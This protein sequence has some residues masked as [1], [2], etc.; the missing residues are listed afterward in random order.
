MRI[1]IALVTACLTFRANTV[2]IEAS[3]YP[4]L[5]KNQEEVTITK[6]GYWVD[7]EEGRAEVELSFDGIDKIK[8]ATAPL[9]VIFVVD[10]ST[11]MSADCNN[12]NHVSFPSYRLDDSAHRWTREVFLNEVVPLLQAEYSKENGMIRRL[13]NG[14]WEID[15]EYTVAL[16]QAGWIAYPNIIAATSASGFDPFGTHLDITWYIA[17]T[18]VT[19]LEWENY[20]LH[21]RYSDKENKILGSRIYATT[22]T[23]GRTTVAMLRYPNSLYASGDCI[24]NLQA[25]YAAINTLVENIFSSTPESHIAITVFNGAVGRNSTNPYTGFMRDYEK[26]TMMDIYW[27]AA[28]QHLTANLGAYTNY[29]AAFRSVLKTLD[30]GSFHNGDDHSNC[31]NKQIV[32]F[33]TD[34]MPTAHCNNG[35]MTTEV[36]ATF[37]VPYNY[38]KP[39]V[40][41]IHK[42]D[43]EIYVATAGIN[44]SD[45]SLNEV[46]AMLQEIATSPKHRYHEKDYEG[47]VFDL[48]Y[49]DIFDSIVKSKELALVDYIDNRYFVVD[50]AA[51][52]GNKNFQ[53]FP[54]Y[55]TVKVEKV[56]IDGIAVQKVSFLYAF[57]DKRNSIHSVKIPLILAEGVQ[58]DSEAGFIPSNYD[59]VAS[60]GGAYASYINLEAEETTIAT[61]RVWLKINNAENPDDNDHHNLIPHP[62]LNEN[63][64]QTGDYF[65]V[66]LFL[67]IIGMASSSLVLALFIKKRETN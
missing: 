47:S 57:S 15:P 26:A 24:S 33:F 31:E 64:P 3:N 60:E 30:D 58:A 11:S 53:Y 41:E 49:E 37:P 13:P 61:S 19:Q 21:Y 44:T 6:K 35:D 39:I 32:I 5:T 20:T 54:E 38:A 40:Q 45:G 62:P 27:N 10:N 14:N 34:G 25:N 2:I 17:N 66:P 65:N 67:S 22:V 18:N 43:I 12:T 28:R 29:E 7:Q 52:A 9:D 1:L 51:L 16:S 55:A 4:D 36:R 48:M 56:I 23:S 46:E 59:P 42:R 63:P 50:E 8:T